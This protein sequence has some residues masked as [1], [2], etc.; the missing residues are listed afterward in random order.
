MK[1]ATDMKVLNFADDTLLYMCFNQVE[2]ME[3]KIN[4]EL[5]KINRWLLGNH[6]KVNATKTKF[7]LF[8]PRSKV[9]ENS[10]LKLK[11]GHSEHLAKVE[12]YK[13]LG[14]IIDSKLTWEPHVKYLTSKLAKTIGVLFRTRHYLN[15]QSLFVIFNSLFLSY[16]R[17]GIICWG[18]CSK[19]TM[20]PLTILM[21]RAIR[22]ILFLDQRESCAT[23][24]SQ[25]KILLIPDM[26]KLEIAK[27]MYCFNNNLLPANFQKYF[28]R[29][30]T[31][32]Q[33]LTRFSLH[34]F[35]IPNHKS[36]RGLR[37]LG[38]MGAN[39]W[40]KIPDSIKF[41]SSLHTFSSSYKT[42]LL[43]SY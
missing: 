30:N 42:M 26:L 22:C 9:W 32:H 19:T 41:K 28:T 2:G 24:L 36:N 15:R 40:S 38:Y 37:S 6:L 25:N 11:I 35:Q 16:L 17:Y 13:Y 39:L 23:H 21:N 14:L 10:T 18:R 12:E 1:F 29:S 3:D 5:E 4:Q 8:H 20:K 7:M 27:F 31:T 43:N 33:H 34:N